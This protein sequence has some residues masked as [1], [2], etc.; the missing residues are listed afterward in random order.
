MRSFPSA[1]Y[2][3]VELLVALAL[4]L[5]LLLAVTELLGRVGGT[6][7]DTRSAMSASANLHEA[8]ILLRQDLAQIPRELATKPQDIAAGVSASDQ[9]GYLEI[10]EGPDTP[11]SHPY[12]DELGNVDPT[13]GDVDDIIGFTVLSSRRGLLPADESF[14][15]VMYKDGELRIEEREAAE[16]IWFV[17]GNTLYRRMRLIDDQ[18]VGD[19]NVNT[20]S[21][22]AHRQRRFGHDTLASGAFPY[23]RYLYDDATN[24]PRGWYYFRMPT[25]EETLHEDWDWDPT[26]F[27][28]VIL[29]GQL[30]SEPN[31]DLWE[32]PYFFPE[33]Q[34]KKSG[35]LTNFVQTPRHVRAGEDVVLTNVLSFDVKVWC[36]DMG[37]FVDLGDP[38]SE[39][40]HD[41]NST[42]WINEDDPS[43]KRQLPRTWDS[44]TRSYG[45]DNPKYKNDK[46]IIMPP[47]AAP[48]EAI[49][50]TIR[51]FDPASRAIK[52]VTVVHRFGK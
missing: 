38:R 14:R 43:D 30:A 48:L 42:E 44:W 7:N 3:L 50:I 19:P 12:V 28:T 9:D 22:L 25:L 8:A 37:D 51:C 33:L 47:Y 35:S 27:S 32:Q 39:T 2:T 17:R 40:W 24:A 16:I 1:A 41:S 36:P 49:Q 21:D 23:P 45:D 29:P 6:M 13:V 5:L 15:G 52:Q 20:L 10:T 11:S 46:G 4:S 31:P 34:D 26:T 18:R